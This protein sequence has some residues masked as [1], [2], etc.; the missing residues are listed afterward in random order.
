MCELLVCSNGLAV[1][2]SASGISNFLLSCRWL[3]GATC[4]IQLVQYSGMHLTLLTNCT[5]E[6]Y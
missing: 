5:V 6:V 1:W 2:Y 3:W 4:T